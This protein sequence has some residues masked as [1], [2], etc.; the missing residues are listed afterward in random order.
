M[1]WEEF[2][3]GLAL[4]LPDLAAGTYVVI[5][6]PGSAGEG[7]Y[8]QFVQEQD[9]LTVE[10]VAN[11]FL[12]SD[13]RASVEGEQAIR[14]AGWSRRQGSEAG[15]WFSMLSWPAY[16]EDYQRLA[17]MVVVALCD[18]YGIEDVGTWRYKAWDE[19]RGGRDVELTRLGLAAC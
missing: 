11:C 19:S 7:R 13:K 18:G 3:D 10:V 5:S 4:E 17:E 12:A 14:A 15:N 8:I 2:S 16:S 1:E 6:E 9:K